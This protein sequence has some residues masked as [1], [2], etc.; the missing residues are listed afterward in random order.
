MGVKMT[1]PNELDGYRNQINQIGK[2]QVKRFTT[3]WQTLD[4]TYKWLGEGRNEAKVVQRL[5]QFTG[6]IIDKRREIFLSQQQKDENLIND[7]VGGV[8]DDV[9]R[10]Q[11]YAMLDT[12]LMAECKDNQIDAHGIQEE[13]NTFVFEGY[14]TTMTAITFTLFMIA[15]HD[16][17]QQKLFN[18]INEIVATGGKVKDVTEMKYLDCVIKESLRLYPPV[19]FI[20]RVL[21]E[22]TILGKMLISII[23]YFRST[24]NSISQ[25]QIT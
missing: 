18:E 22:D 24:E 20:G 19:P 17:V 2:Y 11:R 6:E 10:K 21:G 7:D 25:F 14:D 5:H 23:I 1:K 3:P 13:V 16:D 12:L 8:N 4:F 15:H 9:P